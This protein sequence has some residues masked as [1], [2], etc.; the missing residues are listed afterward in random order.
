M[1][2]KKES[3]QFSLLASKRFLPLFLTQFL[4]ALNDNLYKNALMIILTFSAIKAPGN[5][6]TTMMVNMCAG[7]FILPFFFFSAFAGVL[8]DIKEKSSM[9]RFLKIVEIVTILLGSLGI[10]VSNVYI[11][12]IAL[13][14]LGVQSAFFG[15]LKYSILPQHLSN[16]ELMGGNGL[17]ESGTFIAILIGTIL[18]G[19]LILLDNGNIYVSSLMIAVAVVG[20][21]S[22]KKIP[23]A[24]SFNSDDTK[25]SFIG[26]FKTTLSAGME[27]KSVFLSTLAI[28]WFWFLGATLLAQFPLIVKDVMHA[29]SGMVTILLGVFAIGM[30]VGSVLCEKMSGH[31]V[32][33][34]LVPFG[35]FGITIFLFLFSDGLSM[36]SFDIA[37]N[38][39]KPNHIS[40]WFKYN[41][42]YYAAISLFLV[43][44][45][46]GFFTVPLYAFIQ[47]RTEESKRS[48][49]IGSTNIWNAIFM[50]LSA[51]F[52]MGLS[53]A[54]FILVQM[55]YVLTFLNLCVAIYIFTVVP[56]FMVRFIVW[57][58]IRTIY[59]IDTKNADILPDNGN[60]II[61]CNHVSFLDALFVFGLCPKPVKFV[62]YYK[63]F[64]IPIFK[65]LFNAVGA[66]PIASKAENEQVFN[67]AFKKMNE[68]L[69]AGE[70]VVIFPEGAIT[71]DGNM[72]KF[73][74]GILKMLA[75][76]PVDV[77][78][79]ALSG[80]WG[81]SYSR[82]EKGIL[83]YFPKA[84]FNHKVMFSVGAKI[85][86][87]DV[88]LELLEKTVLELRGS[89][90]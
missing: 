84:F 74:P 44:V 34:G 11:M 19:I 83:R 66:I 79:C 82:K 27:I 65:Y 68:Y 23:L 78:P 40:D 90:L 81:S 54:G 41:N 59:R 62:M 38:L 22:S 42:F 20:Y 29:S 25:I 37:N 15:P 36:I 39:F 58:L 17:I 51:V 18:G 50:V 12:W 16:K 26:S 70:L 46:S 13:F 43:S 32:E 76:N 53:V 57:I 63:I 77:Y 71:N 33:H 73:K 28:S 64:N 4:G 31:K 30:A 52:A 69:N 56:E 55:L 21:I 75:T 72:N 5:L 86:A 6:S 7:I 80:L 8:A 48:K 2:E 88:T 35:A 10:F 24:P 3:S 87:K 60:G 49:I 1:Q 47:Y 89:N 61:V 14:F 67:D 85:P 45:F 9:I